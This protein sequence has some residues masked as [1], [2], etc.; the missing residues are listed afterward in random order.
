MSIYLVIFITLVAALI[1]SFSQ[2]V[3][4]RSME[5]RINGIRD[6]FAL[7]RKRNVILGF[8]GYFISLVIYL[9]ALSG[10]NAPL[11]VVY[12]TFA[13]TF[14]FISIISYFYLKEKFGAVRIAGILLVFAGIFIIAI[15]A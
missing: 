7:F 4:K 6:F 10:K 13:S 3:F 5:K 9:Y 1:A 11:S 8:V 15:S 12:P 14:I 2:I